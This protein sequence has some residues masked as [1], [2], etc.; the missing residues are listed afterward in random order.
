MLFTDNMMMPAKVEH[1]YAAET[2]MNY[3]YEPEVA[4]QDRG[5]RQ[6]RHAGQGRQGD[7]RQDRPEA[8]REPADL[9]ARR[10][11]REAAPVP[12]ALA[13]RG[14]QDA[15]GDGAGDRGLSAH[16]LAA[17]APQAAALAVP[18]A[19]AAVAA[20]LLRASRWST[21]STSRCRRATPS[22]LHLRLGLRVYTDAI[23]DYHEQF[24]RSI[25][26]AATATVLCFVIAFPLAYFIAFKARALEELHA[27]ADHP[28]VL[29]Q[30]PAAD[31]VAGS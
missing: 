11:R 2:M 20:R 31:G 19:G 21:S 3:V 16:A 17:A 29:H 26:Y 8:G 18:G 25:G 5:V 4:A 27:A 14:A 22:G 1:P 7:P 30:L 28:A 9:P 23:S 15:R 13:R 12:G 6:L 10:R 24:L